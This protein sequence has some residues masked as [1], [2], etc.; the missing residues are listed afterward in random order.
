MP[1]TYKMLVPQ[2]FSYGSTADQSMQRS[3]FVKR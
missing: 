1:Y 3:L 2:C